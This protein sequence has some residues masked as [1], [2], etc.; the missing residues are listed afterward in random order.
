MLYIDFSVVPPCNPLVRV[1][2]KS[3]N[4]GADSGAE[5]NDAVIMLIACEQLPGKADIFLTEE[6]HH[7]KDQP[8]SEAKPIPLPY[9]SE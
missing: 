8:H 9:A 6:F 3:G 5:A 2:C 4:L 7:Q 1:D